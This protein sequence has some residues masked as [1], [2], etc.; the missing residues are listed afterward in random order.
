MVLLADKFGH[1]SS[2]IDQQ[3]L[4]ADKRRQVAS[5]TVMNR[6]VREHNRSY[7]A[8]PCSF[9]IMK[10]LTLILVSIPIVLEVQNFAAVKSP[11]VFITADIRTPILE[12]MSPTD[13]LFENRFDHIKTE[14]MQN[15]PYFLRVFVTEGINNRYDY[16]NSMD[17]PDEINSVKNRKHTKS[18]TEYLDGESKLQKGS[19]HLLPILL[20][21][22]VG[23]NNNNNNNNTDAN[24]I[25]FKLPCH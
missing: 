18:T 12:P 17:N 25:A 1:R 8:S 5:R 3:S 23:F 9:S 22:L 2:Y 14:W 20:R 7:G 16:I 24:F 11:P 21:I 4:W 10:F 15:N 6:R 19:H 13:E